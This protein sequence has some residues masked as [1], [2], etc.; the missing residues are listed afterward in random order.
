MDGGGDPIPS[1]VDLLTLPDLRLPSGRVFSPTTLGIE[2][3]TN[4]IKDRSPSRIIFNGVGSWSTPL[5]LSLV[6]ISQAERGV[7]VFHT[8]P[9]G[10]FVNGSHI[11]KLL[12][13]LANHLR[14]ELLN[15]SVRHGISAVA[16]SNFVK[17]GLVGYGF[18]EEKIRVVNPPSSLK[19][20]DN[21]N[22]PY[23]KD[24][25][26]VVGRISHEKGMPLLVDVAK[27]SKEYNLR[28][29]FELA[30]KPCNVD[31]LNQIMKSSCGLIKYAGHLKGED[32]VNFYQKAGLVF[33]PSPNEACPIVAMEALLSG[34]PIMGVS[35]AILEI[36]SRGGGTLPGFYVDVNSKNTV[37]S[38]VDILQRL[39]QDE[40]ARLRRATTLSKELFKPEKLVQDFIDAVI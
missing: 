37:E 13:R 30:G 8:D 10:R 18:P 31:Y 26:R 21:S 2:K 20:P 9:I 7:A 16:V 38:I 5:I 11:H 35:S 6:N 19:I 24:L 33:V 23:D 32:L 39:N 36:L 29:T 4:I 34:T 25:I 27:K 14:L 40:L 17:D 28:F 15:K 22:I 1:K 12:F 3:F